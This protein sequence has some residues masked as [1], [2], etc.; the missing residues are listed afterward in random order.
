MNPP[1][2]HPCY[3]VGSLA[4]VLVLYSCKFTGAAALP[5]F[6]EVMHTEVLNTF[7]NLFILYVGWKSNPR[8]H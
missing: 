5:M 6:L 7:N 3:N 1:H 8:P 2:P 4:L